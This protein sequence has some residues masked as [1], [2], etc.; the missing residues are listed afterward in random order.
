[1]F[2]FTSV[3]RSTAFCPELSP[4][5][6]SEEYFLFLSFFFFSLLEFDTDI[7]VPIFPCFFLIFC[8]S[9]NAKKRSEYFCVT[10]ILQVFNI[11]LMLVVNETQSNL[12][13]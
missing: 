5:Q 11:T 8:C 12:Y 7:K 2:G 6:S 13:F 1:M 3:L 10:S 4:V 9:I